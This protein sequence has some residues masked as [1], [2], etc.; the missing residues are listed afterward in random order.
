MSDT[1]CKTANFNLKTQKTILLL[2]IIITSAA[3]LLFVTLDESTVTL[4]IFK[5]LAKTGAFCG[6]MLIV[7]QFLLGIRFLAASL[8]PD[9]IWILKLHKNIGKYILAIIILHP[10]F[11]TLYY[12]ELKGFNPLILQGPKPFIYFA[13][14]GITAF[15][16]FILVVFTSILARQK[17]TQKTW[18]SFHCTA[19]LALPLVFIHS[20]PIGMTISQPPARY[21]WMAMTI[22]VTALFIFRILC[23]PGLLSKKYKVTQVE[24]MAPGV[25]R[26]DA[27]PLNKRLS[28]RLG[29]FTYLRKGFWANIRPFT[30]S[31]YNQ[32]TGQLSVTVK[33]LGPT[34]TSLQSTKPGDRLYLE[35]PYGIFSHT[36]L[37][38]DKPLVMIAG[39]IGITP[40]RRIFEVLSYEP[41]TEHHL[42]YGN[43]QKH[44]IVY[45]EELENFTSLNLIHVLSDEKNYEGETGYITVP[46]LKKYLTKP[47]NSYEFLICG[48]PVMTLKLE[49]ALTAEN[50]SYT[51]IHHELFSY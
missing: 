17:F 16:I 46:L 49:K 12:L 5:I 34:S 26:I 48:P 14:I 2:T 21:F 50:V 32:N 18:F 39:G 44:E 4:K 37:K 8:M 3:P 51:Q 30:V 40:F 45:K 42:F 28:P 25:T 31:H 24:K 6:T 11:I 27:L 1:N 47:L 35:G 38:S 10:I 13:A 7:W 9:L 36:A 43:K 23:R 29:Q 20:F 19:Y 15:V 41:Q 33:A 22:I